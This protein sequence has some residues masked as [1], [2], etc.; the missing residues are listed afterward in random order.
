MTEEA[1]TDFHIWGPCNSWK[2]V[3]RFCGSDF[4]AVRTSRLL[5]GKIF[6]CTE[7]ISCMSRKAKPTGRSATGQVSGGAVMATQGSHQ[8]EPEREP[9]GRDTAGRSRVEAE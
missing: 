7:Y 1:G 3:A 6:R 9:V 5:P 2:T 8:T 4:G